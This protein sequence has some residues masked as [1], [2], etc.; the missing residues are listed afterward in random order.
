MITEEN[1]TNQL[2]RAALPQ[3]NNIKKR[4]KTRLLRKRKSIRK[5]YTH[6]LIDENDAHSAANVVT[7]RKSE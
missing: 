4:H 7:F 5:H 1:V 2:T 3:N 6:L